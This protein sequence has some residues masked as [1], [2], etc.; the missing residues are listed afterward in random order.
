MIA[1]SDSIKEFPVSLRQTYIQMFTHE[2][3]YGLFRS[4]HSTLLAPGM[5]CAGRPEGG[6]DTCQVLYH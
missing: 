3:C 4:F 1:G 6:H 5:M 2:Y